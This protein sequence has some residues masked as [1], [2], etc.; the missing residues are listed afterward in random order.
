MS[1]K[2]PVRFGIVGFGAMA[3]R[4]HLPIL[5]ALDSIE[6]VGVCD[7]TPARRKA[8]EAIGLPAY[9]DLKEYLSK[10]GAEAT[11]IAAPSGLHGD[12]TVECLKAGHHVMVEKPMA[13]SLEGCDRMINAAREAGRVLSVF[14]NRRYDADYLAV[15]KILRSGQLGKIY[16]IDLRL[17]AWGSGASFGSKDFR[18]KWRLEAGW[19]GG[20]MYDWG[21]HLLDQLGQLVTAPPK[22][23]FAVTRSG[24][25]SKDCDD[26]ARAIIEFEDETT[27]LVEVNYMSRY[28]LPRWQVIAEK[29]TLT[30]DPASWSRLKV[31]WGDR[32]IEEHFPPK[33]GDPSAIYATFAQAVRG[34]G[35]AAISP[36]SARRTMRLLDACLLSAREGHNV[37]FK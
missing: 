10:S 4:G 28:P 20:G 22:N 5:G 15:K 13:M 23:V 32:D 27:G 1:N 31:F 37:E 34:K 14:H 24:V 17:N 35:R 16:S 36:E 7:P 33:P 11:L 30:N 3:E 25:W 19:G 8:A 12:L 6:V 9:K 26:F 29:G 2:Q 18:Q 21:V